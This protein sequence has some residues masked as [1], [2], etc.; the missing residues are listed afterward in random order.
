MGE[1]ERPVVA[2]KRGNACGA[3]GPQRIRAE[4]EEGGSRLDERPTT[5]EPEPVPFEDVDRKHGLPENLSLLRQKL[6]RKAKQEPGFRF[7]ALYDRMYRLDVLWAAWRRVRENAGAPGIDGVRLKDLEECPEGV[8]GFLEDLQQSLQERTYRPKGVRR[9]YIPK[10]NGNL[11]PLGIPTVRD[12]VVQ[13]AA[14]LILE[15]IF[16]ADFKDCSFGFRP[17]RSAHQA[18]AAIKQALT[19]GLQVVYDADLQAYFDS[20]PHD[21]LMA[22]LRKRIADGTVLELIRKWLEAPIHEESE[23]GKPPTVKRSTQ[24]TPQGGVIS[25]LL[26]NIYFHRFDLRFQR[27]DGPAHWAKARLVRYA[28]DFVVLARYLSPGLVQ[29][30]E[31]MLEGRLG[32]K[33]NREKTRVVD[34]KQEGATLH[35]LGFSFRY[36]RDRFGRD[37]RYLNLFP[38]AKALER[39]RQALRELTGPQWGWCELPALIGMINSQVRGWANYFQLGYPRQ[40]F[41][42]INTFV[43][44]RLVRHLRRRSQRAYRPPGDVSWYGF[45]A[46]KG[47]VYL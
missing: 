28:D 16:E 42:S 5:G 13:M 35:F 43:R 37:R 21:P 38:S 47:L 2:S 32:L 44:D 45:L 17:E 11:R 7:Y 34:L 29:F 26:A 12:R 39:E 46:R 3:K 30:I 19:D 27:H 41:R 14:L 22:C 9:V 23:D 8:V 33:I 36:D 4:S 25:P 10:A 31:G 1:S 6:Y 40:A 24:G 18:L 15:P 20:I